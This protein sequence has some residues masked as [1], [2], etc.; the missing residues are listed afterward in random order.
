MV[1]ASF[2]LRDFASE[3]ENFE[4]E[5]EIELL[6]QALAGLFAFFGELLSFVLLREN[7]G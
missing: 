7:F 6:N 2:G 4:A 3:F 1:V 5:H